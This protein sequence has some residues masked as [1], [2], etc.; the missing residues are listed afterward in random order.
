MQRE[1]HTAVLSAG[2]IENGNG[3]IYTVASSQ[4]EI[5]I[6]MALG[7]RP[8]DVFRMVLRH[9]LLLVSAGTLLGIG[10]CL[11][12]GGLL[13]RVLFGIAPDDPVVLAGTAVVMSAVAMAACCLPA[14]RAM[15]VDPINALRA[16]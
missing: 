15:S 3:D 7:A 10:G 11:V 16:E 14:C 4:S 12:V 13:R 5:G 9:A 8:V 6:R 1:A 2:S